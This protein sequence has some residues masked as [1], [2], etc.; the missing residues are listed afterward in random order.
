MMKNTKVLKVAAVVAAAALVGGSA[1]YAMSLGESYMASEVIM[2]EISG[3]ITETGKIHGAENRVYYSKVT[4][5]VESVAVKTG[6]RVSKGETII[7]YDESDL[8]RLLT[9]AEIRTEQAELDYSGK[10][11][12]SDSNASKYRSAKNDDDSYAALYWMYREKG[13]EITE[14]EF[15]RQYA[16]QC[17]IDSVNKEIAEKERELAESRHKKNKATGYGTKDEDDYSE[18]TVKDIKKAE[19]EVDRLNE[20]LS[21]LKKGLYVTSAGAATPEENAA[22][23]DVNNVMEDIT[24]NW[25]EA[26]S[27]KATYENM[28]MNED[29]KEA[30]RKNT[31]LSREEEEEVSEDLRKAE[32]GIKTDFA[33]VITELNVQDGAF[34]TEGTPLFT[35]ETTEDLVC[36][37]EIS[38][39]DIADVK[40]GQKAVTLIGGREYEGVV[41]KI[42]Y[43]ATRD[44]S[45]KSRVEVEVSVPDAGDLAIIDMEADVSIYTDAVDNTL[46]IPVEAFYSDDSGDYCY[47]IREGRIN[48]VYVTSGIVTEDKVEIKSG[49]SQGDIVITD[50]VTDESV[51]GRAR[52]VLN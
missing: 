41:K 12:E 44:A 42:N 29:E 37:A 6:D 48:K 8:K 13:N 35:L 52:Y 28:I 38:R 45:D 40:T 1:V 14:E 27:R 46:I 10:V 4:A 49:L 51:G 2:S 18:K 24:R 20:E 33:G 23:N 32:E 21:E 9:E 30:L 17:Q 7:K 31:E 34:V 5:P 50:S 3:K 26:R 36:R 22:L 15:A 25:T 39:Y 47:T 43:L 19:K 16:V 11:K